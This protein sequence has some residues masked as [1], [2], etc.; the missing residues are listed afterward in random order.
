MLYGE[1]TAP[2]AVTHA[3]TA[4]LVSPNEQNLIV[5]KS[6]LLQIF[7]IETSTREIQLKRH[8][9]KRSATGDAVAETML[10]EDGGEDFMGDD[11]Q[12][13][14]LRHEKVG[15]LI[16][17]EE[18]SLNGNMTGMVNVG[19]LQG[20]PTQADCIAVSFEDAKVYI[21]H[22]PGTFILILLHSL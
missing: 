10:G 17:V 7:R 1:F 14:L 13:Q 19:K 6:T 22:P 3:I 9:T 15:R 11:S 8:D 4:N 2:T 18:I 12:V 16:L 21:L 5:A 20:V